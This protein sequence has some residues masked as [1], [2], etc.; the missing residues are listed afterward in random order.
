MRQPTRV[1]S[2]ERREGHEKQLLE[3]VA[4][5]YDKNK[6]ELITLLDYC[7]DYSS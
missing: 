1:R 4:H 6:I 3:T 2:R 7:R 5:L